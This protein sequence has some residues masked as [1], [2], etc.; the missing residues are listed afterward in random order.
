MSQNLKIILFGGNTE[1]ETGLSVNQIENEWNHFVLTIDI[2]GGDDLYLLLRN[3]LNSAK[4][5]VD[6][7]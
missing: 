3:S 7:I 6:N 5:F 2:N 4:N 1:F